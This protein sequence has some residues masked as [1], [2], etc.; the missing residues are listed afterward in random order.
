MGIGYLIESGQKFTA[1]TT[2][3]PSWI[4]FSSLCD[5]ELH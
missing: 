4:E 2:S 5:D 1:L 3:Y